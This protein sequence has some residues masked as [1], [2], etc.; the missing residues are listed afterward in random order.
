LELVSTFFHKPCLFCDTT[1]FQRELLCEGCRHLRLGHLVRCGLLEVVPYTVPLRVD[2]PK[3]RDHTVTECPVC[4]SVDHVLAISPNLETL[5]KMKEGNYRIQISFGMGFGSRTIELRVWVVY[6]SESRTQQAFAGS[7]HISERQDIDRELVGQKIKWTT[8]KKNISQ[9]FNSHKKCNQHPTANLPE[10]FRVIDVVDRRVVQVKPDSFIALSYVWGVN[11]RLDLLTTLRGTIDAMKKKNGLPAS[12]MPRTIEDAI[13]VCLELGYQYLWVDRI[14]IIQDDQEDKNSQIEAMGSIFQRADLVLIAAYGDSMDY[15]I[16]GVSRQRAQVQRSEYFEDCQITNIISERPNDLDDPLQV[17]SK[18]GWTYQEAALSRRSLVF[19]GSLSFF[20]CDESVTHED[21]YNTVD[22]SH[23][24]VAR[25]VS[26][27]STS[28]FQLFMRH[29][30]DFTLRKLTYQSDTYN[31]FYGVFR[32]L[33]EEENTWLYGLPLKHFDQTL[34]WYSG[35]GARKGRRYE[36]QGVVFPSWSWASHAGVSDEIGYQGGSV[37][38]SKYC[39]TFVAW[40]FMDSAF[41]GATKLLNIPKD[42]DFVENWQHYMAIAC[43]E[44]C[45]EN[46]S[47]DFSSINESPTE[48]DERFGSRWKDQCSFY[49]EAFLEPSGLHRI[50]QS[51]KSG[52]IAGRCQAACLH[53]QRNSVDSLFIINPDFK[54]VGK[55]LGDTVVLKQELTWLDGM[56]S[57][58][59]EFIALSLSSERLSFEMRPE[60]EY[61]DIEGRRLLYPPIVNVMMISWEDGCAYRQAIGWVHLKAWGKLNRKWGWVLLQ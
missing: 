15:G 2:V 14:C 30:R 13:S 3:I 9:C 43:G 21:L 12:H 41:P 55:L 8:V 35:S 42:T 11:P 34:L 6:R 54:V 7:L 5:A 57:S 45:F 58:A 36:L 39:G 10:A 32:A 61:H 25:L 53:L 38:G 24:V 22:Y 1:T 20:Q 16:A 17:W 4:K 37:L 46:I 29:V 28:Q 23:P 56:T 31:A 44:G 49:E 48:M 26:K 33:Y 52:T 19:Y 51:T 40:Y 18:R 27:K 47:F 59:F 60:Y 50:A